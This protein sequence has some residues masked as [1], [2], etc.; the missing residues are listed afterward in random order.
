MGLTECDEELEAVCWR[1]KGRED[2]T[3]VGTMEDSNGVEEVEVECKDD[4][5]L[6]R[7][8]AKA[9]LTALSFLSFVNPTPK[10]TA[11]PIMSKIHKATQ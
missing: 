3:E 7:A 10:P 2:V 6:R 1:A 5:E 8:A 4:E 9:D 11:A